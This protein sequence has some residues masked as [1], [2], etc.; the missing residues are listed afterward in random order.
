MIADPDTLRA[1][2][3]AAVESLNAAH[4]PTERIELHAEVTDLRLQL[5]LAELENREAE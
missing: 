1:R 3:A 2:L 5:R 4:D